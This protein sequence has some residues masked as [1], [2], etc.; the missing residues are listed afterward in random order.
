MMLNEM[1]A[2]RAHSGATTA[3]AATRPPPSLAPRGAR[4][5]GGLVCIA[6][7]LCGAALHAQS[8]PGDELGRAPALDPAALQPLADRCGSE[9]AWATT[10]DEAE[11]RARDEHRGILVFVQL[12]ADF[13]ALRT[14]A[15]M[16]PE[17]VDLIGEHYVPFRFERGKAA[18]IEGYESYGLGPYGFGSSALI[19]EPDG[20]VVGDLLS[21]QTFPLRAFL[22][23]HA[24]GAEPRSDA[25]SGER[26]ALDAA[27]GRMRAGAFAEARKL[28]VATPRAGAAVGPEALYWSGAC[29]TA[30]GD[31]DA[32]TASWRELVEEHGESRWAWWAAAQLLREPAAERMARQLRRPDDETLAFLRIPAA[33]PL[34]SADLL[35]AVRE[36]TAYLLQ[37]QRADGSWRSTPAEMGA[38]A[39]RTDPLTAAVTAIGGTSLL[40]V[41]EGRCTPAVRRALDFVTS[42]CLEQA[43]P[44]DDDFLLD[45][46][47]WGHATALRFLASCARMGLVS[48]DELRLPV[49][50][51]VSALERTQV[52]GGGWNYRVWT[53]VD[54]G[55]QPTGESASFMTAAV[56]LALIEARDLE[57]EIPEALVERGLACL[58]DMRTEGTGFEYFLADQQDAHRWSTEA[59]AA[60]RGPVCTLALYRGGRADLDEL[61]E[62]LD[63]FLRHRA[64]YAREQGKSIMHAA[65]DSQGSHYLLFDYAW[66]AQALAELP[67]S[68]QSVY[69]EALL[70]DVLAARV[71]DGSFLDNAINGRHYGAGMALEALLTLAAGVR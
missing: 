37:H 48:V 58:E 57:C 29:A 12:F 28:L 25:S 4:L 10:W 6:L 39:Y 49:A 14:G 15:L 61:R 68:E 35:Q 18:P 7:L 41:G 47:P 27:I 17:V 40:L 1:S 42:W 26:A 34:A 59:G 30:L 33:D 22:R 62:S 52:S 69:R 64:S 31:V 32:A 45:Y 67:R 21:P 60:G 20:A 13:D 11:K 53:A 24:S 65:P 2:T 51:L 71:S 19:T 8:L 46:S 70:E 38:G 16:D 55:R 63:V 23:E 5:R 50:A 36:G 9:L 54:T 43:T 44:G 56:V 66:S 3:I